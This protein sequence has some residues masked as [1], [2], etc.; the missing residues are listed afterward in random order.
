TG[1]GLWVSAEILRNHNAAVSVRSSQHSRRHGTIF[2]I[3]FPVTTRSG[4][5]QTPAISESRAT[6]ER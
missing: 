2:S 3:S 1:L 5:R 4:V 6:G